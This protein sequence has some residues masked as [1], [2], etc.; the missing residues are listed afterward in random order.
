MSFTD[1]DIKPKSNEDESWWEL[2]CMRIAAGFWGG[3]LARGRMDQSHIN[4]NFELNKSG[5]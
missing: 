4:Q 1:R 3:G 5:P 2:A